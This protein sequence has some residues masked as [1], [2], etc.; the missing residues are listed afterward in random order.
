MTVQAAISKYEFS[1]T[2]N[3]KKI[4]K[5]IMENG[6]AITHMNSTQLSQAIGTSQSSVIKFVKKIGYRS[7]TDFKIQVREDFIDHEQVESLRAQNV[8]LEDPLPDVIRAIYSES[9]ES[10][11]QTYINLD[12]DTVKKC[13][14]CIENAKRIYICGKGASYLP[15][16]DLSTKL[17]KFG[18]TVICIQDL[19]TM[20][21]TAGSARKEDLYFF[22]SFSGESEELIRIMKRARRHNAE[23]VL[24]TKNTTS[25]LAELADMCIGIVTNEAKYRAASMSSRIVF[26]SIV[27][28]LFLGVLKNDLKN[29][30]KKLPLEKKNSR[31]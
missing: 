17:M 26:F 20:E 2:E 3:E 16:Y 6:N 25:T 5:Y 30:L 24:V 7:F 15:A 31:R 9:I 23:T 22:F 13:I 11:S 18:M 21:V 12:K 28:V 10:L 19:E 29:R 14:S 1:F 27:D 8:S 4:M